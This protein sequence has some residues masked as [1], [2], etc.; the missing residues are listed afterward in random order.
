MPARGELIGKGERETLVVAAGHHDLERERAPRRT[1]AQ[2]RA[3]ELVAGGFEQFERLAQRVAVAIGAVADRRRPGAVEHVGPHRVRIGR[4][5]GALARVRRAMIGRQFG[6]V[7][8]ARAALIE[9]EEEIA[10]DP[11]ESRTTCAIAC[12]TRIS[13]K[14]GRRVLNT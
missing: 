6:I 10:V 13:A 2:R 9:I 5:Q 11:F 14:I 7:E 4:Q 1:V 12:R 3:F 8:E